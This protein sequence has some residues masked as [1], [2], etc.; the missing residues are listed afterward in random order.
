MLIFYRNFVCKVVTLEVEPSDTIESVRAKI[1][2]KE[3]MAP[4][5]NKPETPILIFC[6]KHLQDEKTLLDYNIVKEDTLTII[7]RLLSCR[8]CSKY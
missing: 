7:G 1:R 4:D 8:D 5:H 6:G 3:G 2:D